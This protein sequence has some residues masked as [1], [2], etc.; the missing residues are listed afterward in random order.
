MPLLSF[1]ILQV[2]TKHDVRVPSL[3]S[4][5]IRLKNQFFRV[6]A[7]RAL[8][9][10]LAPLIG[11]EEELGG[12]AVPA[13]WAEGADSDKLASWTKKGLE[14]ATELDRTTQE[15]TAVEY[16]YLMRKV[17]RNQVSHYLG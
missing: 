14:L 12:K 5:L 11:A 7:I 16:G 10:A 8:L 15:T 2:S 6:Y 3:T 1:M 4:L 17:R 13:G 9:N